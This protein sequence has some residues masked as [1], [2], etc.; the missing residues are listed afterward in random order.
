ML[1]AYAAIRDRLVLDI[2]FAWALPPDSVVWVTKPGLVPESA[3]SAWVQRDPEITFRNLG[4]HDEAHLQMVVGARFPITP[5]LDL[6]LFTLEKAS[7]LRQRIVYAHYTECTYQ[8]MV[9]SFSF[10]D[11]KPGDDTV[12]LSM[13]I[14]MNLIA[15]RSSGDGGIT[16]VTS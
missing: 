10:E 1:D 13:T 14:T 12:E 5:G 2:R 15:E 3:P 16:P 11:V 8:P 9:E 4:I 7:L 6:D